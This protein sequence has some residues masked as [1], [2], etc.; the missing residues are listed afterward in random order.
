MLS[1][2]ATTPVSGATVKSGF[3]LVTAV[4]ARL[5]APPEFVTVTKALSLSPTSTAP[6]STVDGETSKTAAPRPT[7]RW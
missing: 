7:V 2:G 3:E 6:R 5:A 4:T 1:S